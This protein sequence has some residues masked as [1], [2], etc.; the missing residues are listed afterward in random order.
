MPATSPT[1]GRVPRRFAL[2]ITSNRLESGLM[3][4]EVPRG[5]AGVVRAFR[6]HERKGLLSPYIN[7]WDT[8]PTPWFDKYRR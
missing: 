5:D 2:T 1:R 6:P 7:R 4:S 3:R 8:G